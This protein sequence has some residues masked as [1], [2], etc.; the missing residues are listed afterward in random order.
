MNKLEKLSESEMNAIIGGE[1]ITVKAVENGCMIRIRVNG[2]GSRFVI[3]L[4]L[5]DVVIKRVLILI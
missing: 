2:I 5:N 3:L 1:S 4:T